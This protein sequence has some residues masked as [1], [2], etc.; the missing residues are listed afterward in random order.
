M[1]LAVKRRC[2]NVVDRRSR[3]RNFDRRCEVNFIPLVTSVDDD[4]LLSGRLHGHRSSHGGR[5][6]E[7]QLLTCR[8]NIDN[9]S[10]SCPSVSATN[11]TSSHLL[12]NPVR[13]NARRCETTHAALRGA[14][15][16]RLF[17]I[18]DRAIVVSG[19]WNR[20]SQRHW[21]ADNAARVYAMLRDHGFTA[22]NV[23]VF[24]ADGA[25]DVVKCECLSYRR[26]KSVAEDQLK[27]IG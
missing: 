14:G 17:E 2:R 22:G 26:K 25:S 18:C 4:D 9:F 24:F 10:T 13:E 27:K 11:S 23:K 16:C 21:H 8:T 20:W 19:G 5:R 12:C 1:V 7:H 3:R 6:Q 15:R